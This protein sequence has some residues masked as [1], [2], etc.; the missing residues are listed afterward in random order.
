L[1]LKDNEDGE[2]GT[3]DGSNEYT[4]SRDDAERFCDKDGAVVFFQ[5]RPEKA[6]IV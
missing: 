6:S 3:Y 1:D 4:K 2:G 5:S